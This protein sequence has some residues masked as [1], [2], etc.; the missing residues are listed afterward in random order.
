[1]T[2]INAGRQPNHAFFVGK[3]SKKALIA[4]YHISNTTLSF[5]KMKIIVTLSQVNLQF[6]ISGLPSLIVKAGKWAS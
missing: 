3:R 1:M 4:F 6:N 2:K 5:I